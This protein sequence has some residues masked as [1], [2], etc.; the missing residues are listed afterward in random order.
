M[1]PHN[2]SQGAVQLL[3]SNQHPE[4]GEQWHRAETSVFSPQ[5]STTTASGRMLKKEWLFSDERG[6][7]PRGIWGKSPRD[8]CEF[9]LVTEAVGSGAASF[10]HEPRT[11]DHRR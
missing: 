4:G 10:F 3:F 11:E 2:S 5:V 7:P 1:A 9:R 8:K 6:R